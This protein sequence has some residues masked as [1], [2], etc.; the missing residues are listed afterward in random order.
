MDS[1]IC[2]HSVIPV[3][4]EP[5]HKSEMVTQVLF[6]EL[7]QITEKEN[8]WFKIRLEFDN[9]EGWIDNLQATLIDEKE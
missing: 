3:R 8:S 5:S 7:Y 2:L 1:G 9:Y 6:G 4:A